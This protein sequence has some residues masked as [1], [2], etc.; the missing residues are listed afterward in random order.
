MVGGPVVALLLWD[1]DAAIVPERFAHEREL[2][3]VIATDRN[4]GGV[5]L[6]VAGVGKR[7]SAF[8]GAERG[9]YV[10]SFCIGGEVEDIA[11]PSGREDDAVGCVR[12]N[13]AR[14]EIAYHDAF[15]VTVHEDDIE[16]FCSWEHLD[17]TRRDLAIQ[18]RVGSEEELLA[19]LTAG[20][21]GSRDLG[22]AEGSVVEE[23]AV[24]ASEGDAEC[25]AVIDDGNADFGET[26]NIC[27]SGSEVAAFDGVVE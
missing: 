18:R 13:R 6:G 22:T 12:G 24:F 26:V 25:D 11:V 21:E 7:R 14:D 15:C 27:F 2:G 3:L 19:G 10:A 8:V 5:D 20:V 1:P 23:S 16:H 9:C 17:G 4:A